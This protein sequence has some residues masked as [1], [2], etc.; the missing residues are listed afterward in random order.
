MVAPVVTSPTASVK[1]VAKL[2]LERRI[3]A[4]SVVD[5]QDKLVGIVSGGDLIHRSV[6]RLAWETVNGGSRSYVE[7]AGGG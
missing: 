4:V 2:L 1:D 3:S 5:D 6:K 7:R